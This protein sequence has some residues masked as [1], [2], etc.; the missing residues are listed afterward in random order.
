MADVTYQRGTN[1][2]GYTTPNGYVLQGA[3]QGASPLPYIGMGGT[4]TNFQRTSYVPTLDTSSRPVTEAD[5]EAA[6]QAQAAAVGRYGINT[7]GVTFNGL[8]GGYLSNYNPDYQGG[9]VEA[10]ING[11]IVRVPNA[12]LQAMMYQDAWNN[13]RSNAV[14]D[15]FTGGQ[16][17]NPDLYKYSSIGA[18]QG[19]FNQILANNPQWNVEGSL[20]PYKN[21]QDRAEMAGRE[22]NTLVQNRAP[23][24]EVRNTLGAIQGEDNVAIQRQKEAA[25]LAKA[26]RLGQELNR[27]T[28]GDRIRGAETSSNMVN[29][30]RNQFGQGVRPTYSNVPIKETYIPR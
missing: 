14:G 15:F 6:R 18:T 9:I 25:A 26:R 17:P 19:R 2:A 27:Q 30:M 13:G 16:N 1:L 12:L 10:N 29:N 23:I 24:K 20:N 5:I 7:S 4:G 3:R 22:Y 21:L 11:E 28:R 8:R